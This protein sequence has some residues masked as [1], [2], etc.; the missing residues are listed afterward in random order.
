MVA[1]TSGTSKYPTVNTTKVPLQTVRIKVTDRCHWNCYWCHNEG[2]GVRDPKV[3]CDMIWDDE[4]RYTLARLKEEL[5]FDELHLTGGEPTAH[6]SLPSL[7]REMH[8]CGYIIKMT[9]IGCSE[10]RLR[11]L[12]NSGL[13]GINVSLHA[14]QPHLLHSTQLD[15]TLGWI[16]QQ[17]QQQITTVLLAKAFGLQVKL[18]TVIAG[19]HDINRVQSVF[20]WAHQHN[21]P[22]RLMNEVRSG[23]NAISAALSFARSVGAIEIERKHIYGSSSY[24]IT[25]QMNDGYEFAVKLIGDTYLEKSMC[26]KCRVRQQGNCQEKFYGVR[27][28]RKLHDNHCR[29]FVR[30][31]IHRTDVDT[32]L[33]VDKF[34]DSDQFHELRAMI[35]NCA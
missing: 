29:L 10:R 32:Y 3:I 26:G 4:L 35:T 22:L 28:E 19:F 7:I 8:A 5:G 17:L 2:S 13:M 23:P 34:F 20:H 21:L 11:E 12:V 9:S 30:L 31:C 15:R 16:E 18:N 14:V 1:Q 6:P 25:F 33:P 27:L 24:S